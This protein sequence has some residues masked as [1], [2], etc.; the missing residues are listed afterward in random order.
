M[1]LYI[2]RSKWRKIIESS[3][4]FDA[5]YYRSQVSGGEYM[6]DS[7]LLDH[8][9]RSGWKLGYNPSSSF[10]TFIYCDQF[11]W[12]NNFSYSPLEHYLFWGNRHACS[13]IMVS[14]S[15]SIVY[16]EALEK[17]GTWAKRQERPVLLISH[18]YSNTGAPMTLLWMAESMKKMGLAPLM[19]S[20]TKGKLQGEITRKGI[21]NIVVDLFPSPVREE[22]EFERLCLKRFM[23]SFDFVLFNCIIGLCWAADLPKID[24][25]CLCWIHDGPNAMR[26]VFITSRLKESIS[27]MSLVYAVSQFTIDAFA[28]HCDKN[29]EF[30]L[31]PYG[32][33]DIEDNQEPSGE[34][35]NK[36]PE[37]VKFLMPGQ[38]SRRKG[39]HILLEVIKRLPDDCKIRII[40]AGPKNDAE[41][42]LYE[43][44]CNC[45]EADDRIEYRGELSHDKFIKLY[46]E[47]DV[48]LCPSLADPL[49]IVCA[50]AM[51]KKKAVI[52]S[53]HTGTAGLIDDKKNGLIVKAGNT[54]SLADA[55]CYAI[56]HPREMKEV[57]RQ[58]RKV[59]EE[60]FDVD[61]FDRRVAQMV[62]AAYSIKSKKV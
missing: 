23:E 52:V 25:P 1:S 62:D 33:L 11:F 16:G 45:A 9:L 37:I 58:G 22:Y 12:L 27:R 6:S 48:V 36:E 39:H 47:V 24:K 2:K 32:I 13:P 55:I 49:P 44:V 3:G 17:W 20:L 38:I 51:S 61:S 10:C 41:Q 29:I 26:N 53:D 7:E 8:Y 15:E 60:V 19:V 42:S 5:D 43:Q 21:E 31:F 56:E 54:D 46:D 28:P 57:G 4:L 18:E 35:S 30:H 59:F 40:I 14:D 34:S 50:E